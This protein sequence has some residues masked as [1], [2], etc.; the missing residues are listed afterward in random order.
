MV[1]SAFGFDAPAD[2]EIAQR[3][4][5]QMQAGPLAPRNIQDLSGGEKQRVLLARALAQQTPHLILDEPT[6]QLDLGHS[7]V[8]VET[9]RNKV[10]DGRSVVVWASHDISLVAAVADRVLVLT[11]GRVY[12][13]GVPADVINEEM[14]G[15]VYGASYR[16]CKDQRTGRPYVAPA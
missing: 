8:L 6:S 11:G 12:H 3:A 7:Q 15:K 2:F 5:D 9:L 13:C 10:S 16:V 14:I 1:R 4:L